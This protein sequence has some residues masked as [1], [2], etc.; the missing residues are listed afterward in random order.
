MLGGFE[1]LKL[2]EMSL[3]TSVVR[4]NVIANNIANVDVPGF[5]RSEVSFEAELKRAIESQRVIDEEEPL[6]TTQKE[7]IA[8]RRSKPLSAIRP[9]VHIDYNSTMRNDGNNVDIED[10][11]MKMVRN[12]LHFSLIADRVSGKF[13]EWNSFIRMA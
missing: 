5:K 12:Q 4:R 9:E 10:E 2:L 13:Q 8:Y 6:K 11:V 3:D 7:H 1:N